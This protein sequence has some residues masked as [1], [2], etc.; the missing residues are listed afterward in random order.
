MPDEISTL[1][2]D[3]ASLTGRF[4]C[5]ESTKLEYFELQL[6]ALNRQ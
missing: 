5:V 1:S 2:P 3:L 4:H 6:L